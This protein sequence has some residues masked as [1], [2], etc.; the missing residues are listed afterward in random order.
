MV[1]DAEDVNL[2]KK[3]GLPGKKDNAVN[4]EEALSLLEPLHSL[5][6]KHFLNVSVD[7]LNALISLSDMDPN[8]MSTEEEEAYTELKEVL[9]KIDAYRQAR[10]ALYQ[11]ETAKLEQDPNLAEYEQKVLAAIKNCPSKLARLF[12]EVNTLNDDQ[13]MMLRKGLTSELDPGSWN[14]FTSIERLLNNWNF[15]RRL[16]PGKV[17]ALMTNAIA[18][19]LQPDHEIRLP[20]QSDMHPNGLNPKEMLLAMKAKMDSKREFDVLTNN[21]ANNCAGILAAGASAGKHPHIFKENVIGP[22]TNQQMVMNNARTYA[23]IVNHERKN[24]EHHTHDTRA[25]PKQ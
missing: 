3:F 16:S 22:L 23:S 5:F 8:L 11:Y 20:L 18:F 12:A 1:L 10:E 25:K 2:M 4:I 13:V 15:T 21:C 17:N 6:N 14:A 7:Y 19:G 9:Q 24:T